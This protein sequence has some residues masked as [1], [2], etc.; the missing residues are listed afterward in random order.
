VITSVDV[1]ASL[2]KLAAPHPP[3]DIELDG[4]D[5]SQTLLGRAVQVRARPLYWVRPPDRPA[6]HGV[7]MPDLAV[8]DGKWKLL[9]EDDG[10]K[11]LLFD[12]PSDPGETNDLADQRPEIV[13][14]LRTQL[15]KWRDEVQEN[16]RL[17][18][19]T[20]GRSSQTSGRVGKPP[21]A[22]KAAISAQKIRKT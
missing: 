12:I 7:E 17:L 5:L 1:V 20:S 14:R 16:R 13:R 8:R 4:E 19:K 6:I 3:T 11:P 22:A 10:T 21:K 18:G 2:I 9:L 15:L